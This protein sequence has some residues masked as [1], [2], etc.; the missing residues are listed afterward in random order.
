VP[1]SVYESLQVPSLENVKM[2]QIKQFHTYD[3]GEI[4]FEPIKT[5]FKNLDS[6]KHLQLQVDHLEGTNFVQATLLIDTVQ[7]DPSLKVYLELFTSLLFE[8]PIRN[9][10]VDLTHGQVVYE[11][12]KDL[13]EFGSPL[14][15]NGSQFE[16]GIFSEYF[17]VFIKVPIRDYEL[18]IKWI[19]WVLF[20]TVFDNKQILIAVSNLLKEIK[21][22][23]QQPSDLIHSV[24][25]DIYFK[26]EANMCKNNFLKQEA[27]LQD[28]QDTLTRLDDNTTINKLNELRNSILI[29]KKLRFYMC[30]D[31]DKLSKLFPQKLDSIWLE[32]FPANYLF[33]EKELFT[34]NKEFCVQPAWKLKKITN[35]NLQNTCSLFTPSSKRDFLINLGTSES[36]YLSIRASL[37]IDSY[38]HPN[39]ASLL[40][41]IEYFCQVEVNK[42][43]IFLFL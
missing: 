28:I 40:V 2:K 34:S 35:E 23:K 3:N 5:H 33:N 11:L 14:G 42:F 21:K 13:L 30:A 17:T 41:L 12:N 32:H 16:P 38:Y 18:G 24:L 36:A 29:D 43:I 27:F 10:E 39:Y 7:L 26:E 4:Q 9:S 8:S 20:N 6:V 15:I 22:R 37:D 31:I 1:D 19:K 25:N